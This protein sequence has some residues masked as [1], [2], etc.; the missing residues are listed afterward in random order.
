MRIVRAHSPGA[1]AGTV[2]AISEV[3]AARLLEHY[4]GGEPDAEIAE[5]LKRCWQ[6]RLWIACECRAQHES[7]PM[8]FVR[9]IEEHY[10]LARMTDRPPHMLACPFAAPPALLAAADAAEPT[11]PQ[12]AALLFRWLS[13]AKLNVIY[14]YEH[15]DGL[16]SQFE[17][18]RE[19]ARNLQIAPGRRLYDFSRT[20][21]D[22]LAALERRLTSTSN[23]SGVYLARVDALSEASLRER[24][25]GAGHTTN[26]FARLPLSDLCALVSCRVGP[27]AALFEF[28]PGT[29]QG[30]WHAQVFTHPV[31]S[32]ECLIPVDGE[33]ERYTLRVLLE[34]Q[35]RLLRWRTSIITIRKTLPGTSV[36]ERGIGMQ[37]QRLG[38]N[39]RAVQSV[40][41]VSLEGAGSVGHA[42]LPCEAHYHPTGLDSTAQAWADQVFK[43]SIEERL[44]DG[45][46]RVC[47]Q[48]A[49]A[50]P[51]N[52]RHCVS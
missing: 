52:S 35:Q 36:H 31:L 11:M 14:P 15:E 32:R 18:L 51:G 21:A 1:F 13:A 27:F 12:P 43:R 25:Y 38:P 26:L 50:A 7:P 45:T 5:F 10:V 24:L 9:R 17:A 22:G 19:A 40:D 41:V 30:S 4:S 20:H 34:L 16:H 3:D 23:A 46:R 6:Q 8:L 47:R 29:A 33:H 28:S 42:A 48:G 49:P 39:G 2:T 37:V 44:W